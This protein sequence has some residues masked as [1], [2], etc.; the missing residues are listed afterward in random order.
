MTVSSR[1]AEGLGVRGRVVDDDV[2][3]RSCWRRRSAFASLD[4]RFEDSWAVWNLLR[5]L[6]R[7]SL[8]RGMRWGRTA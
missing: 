2:V 8:V 7:V 3:E 5:S 6:R 1:W 4:A